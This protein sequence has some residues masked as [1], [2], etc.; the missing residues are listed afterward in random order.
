MRY[1]TPRMF[2]YALIFFFAIISLWHHDSAAK[3]V[4]LPL[5]IN[6]PILDALVLK[7]PS[8]QGADADIL[9][10][11]AGPNLSIVLV[12]PSFFAEKGRLTM[13]AG[14]YFKTGDHS[15]EKTPLSNHWK[16]KVSSS[17]KPAVDA[18]LF[19]TFKDPVIEF[20]RDG[21]IISAQKSPFPEA[22]RAILRFFKKLRIDL[23]PPTLRLIHLLA[24]LFAQDF[25]P[26]EQRNWQA[27]PREI[28][29]T[30]VHLQIDMQ[31]EDTVNHIQTPRK[32]R[33]SE[34][35]RSDI[36]KIWETWDALLV[37]LI[38]SLAA[39]PLNQQEQ[40]VLF[41]TLMKTRYGFVSNFYKDRQ[42]D[43]FVREQ[44]ISAWETISPVFAKI[45]AHHPSQPVENYMVLFSAAK[46]IGQ[47]SRELDTEI[48]IR[49][50]VALAN[51]LKQET[52]AM[53][54]Y[55]YRVNSLLRKVLGFR[56]NLDLPAAEKHSSSYSLRDFLSFRAAFAM[57]KKAHQSRKDIKPWIPPKK[58]MMAYVNKVRQL[59]VSVSDHTLEKHP[60]K[61]VHHEIFKEIAVSTAWQE[62]C[63]RQFHLENGRAIFLKSWN[64]TSVGLMQINERVWRGFY[65]IEDLRWNIRYN[66]MAGCE[67]LKHYFERILSKKSVPKGLEK[68][69]FIA[70][71]TYAMYNAGPGAF[72]HFLKQFETGKLPLSG[73][74]YARKLSWTKNGQWQNIHHCLGE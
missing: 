28:T 49:G 22:N 8:D 66:A 1:K 42:K 14:I 35:P 21:R 15:R 71:A 67:I 40:D 59:L 51:L 6:Y 37:Y 55:D 5:V 63:F 56:S 58:N 70:R 41:E 23:E 18:D 57:E 2:I 4:Y 73:R 53:L 9:T 61:T 11:P 13:E 26:P 34:L 68:A 32:P 16:G 7:T 47:L 38:T 48:D 36:L 29:V 19:L 27:E 43:C 64:H 30:P 39:E 45:V 31:V 3:D 12:L 25:P 65:N 54:T 74:L 33:G 72:V 24:P 60:S 46:S 50:L 44:F 62:S 69:D 17:V 20:H 52:R 10:L